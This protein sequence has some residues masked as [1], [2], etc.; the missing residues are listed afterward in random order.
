MNYKF[1]IDIYIDKNRLVVCNCINWLNKQ[2]CHS[3]AIEF[4]LK[5][6]KFDERIMS[7]PI[8]QKRKRRRTKNITNCL[9]KD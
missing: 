6:L 7:V 2:R 9:I 5:S 8:G 1:Y 4:Y 3:I